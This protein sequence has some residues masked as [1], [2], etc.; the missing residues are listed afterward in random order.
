MRT[1]FAGPAKRALAGLVVGT[2]IAAAPLVG[3]PSAETPEPTRTGSLA[4]KSAEA[5]EAV[6]TRS[7][8]R[9]SAE[10]VAAEAGEATCLSARRK[11]WVDGRGWIVR[12]VT[13]CT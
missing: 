1:D 2:L 9:T 3:M 8:T 5:S 11:M 6:R 12:Q 4:R 7:L 13:R 10:P